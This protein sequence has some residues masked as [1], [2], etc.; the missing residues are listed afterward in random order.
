[1]LVRF[2]PHE[3][4][5][6]QCDVK[7]LNFRVVIVIFVIVD[8]FPLITILKTETFNLCPLY[9]HLKFYVEILNLF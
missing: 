9:I 1:M 2:N 4:M 3:L 5:S 7:F 6:Y 8:G